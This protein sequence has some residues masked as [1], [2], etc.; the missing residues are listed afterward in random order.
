MKI[1]LQIIIITFLLLQ[2]CE[3]S[4]LCNNDLAIFEVHDSIPKIKIENTDTRDKII[5]KFQEQFGEELCFKKVE[6]GLQLPNEAVK[7]Y[8]TYYCPLKTSNFP[9]PAELRIIINP[10]K[11]LLINSEIVIDLNSID[12]WI[13]NDF[14]PKTNSELFKKEIAIQWNPL[15]PANYLDLAVMEIVKG[16][17]LKLN[18]ISSEK[19]DKSFCDLNNEQT[20]QVRKAFPYKIVFD[21]GIPPPP[22]PPPFN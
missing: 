19:F 3:K 8:F 9:N 17:N 22:P 2:S 14:E 20:N 21:I 12:T 18:S 11:E 7:T 15:T 1:T 4:D 10:Q 16:F 6:F 5:A 13:L